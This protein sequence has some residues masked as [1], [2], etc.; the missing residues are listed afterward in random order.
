MKLKELYK[1]KIYPNFYFAKQYFGRIPYYHFAKKSCDKKRV[2]L[3][4]LKKIE[5]MEIQEGEFE[6]EYFNF[7]YLHNML[8]L[9][10][11]SL[12]HNKYPEIC[13]NRGKE[14]VIQWE[15]YF[16]P[17]I[18]RKKSVTK[19]KKTLCNK[20]TNS[21]LPG[22]KDIYNPKDVHIWCQ[23]Y[24]KY[25]CLNAKTREYVE[26]E[27]QELFANKKRVLGIICRGTDYL[28]LKPAGHPVQPSIQEIIEF[29]KKHMKHNKYDAIYLA[30]EERQI[31]DLFVKEF[32]G[33]ILENKRKY[34]DDIYY[35]DS[36]ISYIKDVHFD[37]EN[38]NYLSGLEYLSS[39]ILLSR[40]T[41]VIGGNCGG[42][43][44]AIFFNNEKYEFT[45]VF[46]LGLYS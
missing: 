2:E 11:Y 20:K 4:D 32:P 41:S 36:S 16:E 28:A 46:D 31:R 6:Y 21:F 40:C 29:C 38:D 37:R 7:C 35:K 26:K 33:K 14:N 44:G 22:F 45:H 19:V 9:I 24:K 5:V 10:I 15:W 39:I 43:L 42:T 23:W 12:Y 25:I 30:T 34:Y 1:N 17:L 13:V 3:S 18:D 27:Y 8:S